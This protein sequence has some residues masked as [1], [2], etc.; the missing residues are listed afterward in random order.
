MLRSSGVLVLVLMLSGCAGFDP[1]VL[2]D[3]LG[4]A[5][6]GGVRPVDE[7]EVG[8]GLREALRV[9]T[10]RAVGRLAVEDG[11]L[12]NEF[13]R[14]EL[15]EELTE[16]A[17]V[18]RRIGL[19][20]QVDRLEVA[21]NRAAEDAASTATDVFS[22]VVSTMTIADAWGILRGHE[23]AATDYFRERAWA[24][25]DSRFQPIIDEKMGQVGLYRN[26]ERLA[27]TYNALPF[28]SEPAV[29]LDSYLTEEALDGLF[30]ELAKEEKKIREDPIAR[31][32]ELL[33]RVF[34][35][36]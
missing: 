8:R 19:G 9:G 31:T 21:M 17:S 25:L 2:N 36:K 16:M 33:R 11:Y 20:G 24:D 22:G 32:T 27:E 29:D 3:V 26:Y 7:A 10:R 28:V 4:G 1:A 14:I 18:L 6:T 30:H 13:V 34:S 23:T 12:G 5:Q 35:A 15:P